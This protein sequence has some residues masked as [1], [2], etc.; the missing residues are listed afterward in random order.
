MHPPLLIQE[1]ATLTVHQK[2]HPGCIARCPVDQSLVQ[3]AKGHLSCNCTCSLV[4]STHI[5][6]AIGIDLKCDLDLRHSTWGWRD[7]RE[8]KLAQLVVVLCHG[9]LSL[10]HL[11]RSRTREQDLIAEVLS[12]IRAWDTES[13]FTTSI[14]TQCCFD[15]LL[16]SQQ[17]QPRPC[18][19]GGSSSRCAALQ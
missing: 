5:E 16:I 12:C 3:E 9:T 13:C 15:R 18:M 6:D 14:C 1:G 19:A 17:P 8:V 10:I 4:L 2:Q 11:H 7:A